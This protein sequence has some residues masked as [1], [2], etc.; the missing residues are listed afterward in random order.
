MPTSLLFCYNRQMSHVFG[1]HDRGNALYAVT[2]CAGYNFCCHQFC[3]GLRNRSEPNSF[4][5]R[6][7]S[8]SEI[9]PSTLLPSL[10]TTKASAFSTP[11]I[12]EE[13]GDRGI[14][15]DMR[16]AFTLSV[17]DAL[18]RH[19]ALRALKLSVSAVGKIA[20]HYVGLAEIFVGT[21]IHC[22]H[23]LR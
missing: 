5:P 14:R 11:G 7:T 10:L 3:T 21:A 23:V 16:S 15:R 4:R 6:T 2:G 9:M 22:T 18:N 8:C 20:Q 13:V 1:D 12:L 19:V 17:K